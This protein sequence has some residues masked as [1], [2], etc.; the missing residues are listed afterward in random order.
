MDEIISLLVVFSLKLLK[1][2]T[3][4]FIIIF[5]RT[6]HLIKIIDDLQKSRRLHSVRAFGHESVYIGPC[7]R[8]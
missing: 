7:L 3:E 1:V 5:V 2:K 8:V 4:C 6:G